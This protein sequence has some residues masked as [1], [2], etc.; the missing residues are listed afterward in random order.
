MPEGGE[1]REGEGHETL[2]FLRSLCLRPLYR[3]SSP[4]LPR[5][6]FRFVSSPSDFPRY[7]PA[8]PT[9]HPNLLSFLPLLRFDLPSPGAM[10]SPLLALPPFCL[11][12]PFRPFFPP[13][14]FPSR[15][16]RY[17]S[18]FACAS[19]S[20]VSRLSH[21]RPPRLSLLPT[22]IS[23]SSLAPSLTDNPPVFHAH[24]SFS[25][26]RRFAHPVS[27]FKEKRTTNGSMWE[28]SRGKK[29]GRKKTREGC[30]SVDFFILFSTYVKKLS[31]IN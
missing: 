24:V 17:H 4:T 7:H 14:P 11:P 21:L 2:L 22:A 8:N 12:F 27:T 30:T 31:W 9:N 20:T 25:F 19:S 10:P 1:L 18:T 16:L 28:N 5:P 6:P 23:Q 29:G 13:S 3:L 15:T 26:L